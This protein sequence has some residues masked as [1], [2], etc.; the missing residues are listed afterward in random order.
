MRLSALL[1]NS[2]KLRFPLMVVAKFVFL[3]LRTGPA[4]L[5]RAVYDSLSV[6][7]FV[8][9]D[10]EYF[11]VSTADKTIGRELFLHGEFDFHKLQLALAV[12]AREK[13]PQR[14]HLI[15]V[16]A[17]I[18]TIVIPALKRGLFKSA[19]ALEPSPGNLRLLRANLVLNVL[20]H[21]V[22]ILEFAV[23]DASGETLHLEESEV[24]SGNHSIGRE[25][26]PVS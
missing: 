13:L 16:G 6:L 24:N 14:C 2:K 23:G 25:G 4:V 11:V 22:E 12:L 9:G 19:T 21:E 15:D 20:L 7:F 3:L 26:L 10:K 8:A 18:G 17:N 1:R 5:G